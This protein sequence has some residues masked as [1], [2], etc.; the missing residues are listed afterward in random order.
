M[1]SKM[2]SIKTEKNAR[3]LSNRAAAHLELEMFHEA[4]LDAQE[5]VR[6]EPSEK[7]YYRMARA[8][9]S[10]RQFIDAA[11]NFRKCLE[12]NPKNFN[13]KEELMRSQARIKESETGEY[14]MKRV[15]DD[16]KTGKLRLDVADYVSSSI[17]I[18]E[19]KGKG[20]GVVAKEAIKRGTLLVASKA[21][22]ISYERELTK[23]KV[24]SVNFYTNKMDKPAHNQN[25]CDL[26]YKLQ[27]DPYLAKKVKS[28]F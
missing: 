26:F 2:Y 14:D 4:F 19:L 3:T 27:H 13:A 18:R 8:S 5:S 15:V 10:M 17:E 28:S 20:K 1:T 23:V 16:V 24:M 25:Q 6:L 9:Y 12:I 22:S 7:A 11:D 21:A